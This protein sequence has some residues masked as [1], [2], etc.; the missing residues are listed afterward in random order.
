MNSPAR[1]APHKP[2]TFDYLGLSPRIRKPKRRA[3]DDDASADAHFTPFGTRNMR[4]I[5]EPEL[6]DLDETLVYA[7]QV[8][9][10][11]LARRGGADRGRRRTGRR[12]GCARRTT[13]GCAGRSL[14]RRRA[15]RAR[16]WCVARRSLWRVLLTAAQT[17]GRF[18]PVAY[19]GAGRRYFAPLNG[20]IKPDTTRVRQLLR[21]GGYL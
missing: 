3:P 7:F 10:P 11:P 14:A 21:E 2:P 1:T 18:F 15:L 6:A 20:N 16:A 4:P 9:V 8:S 5:E 17:D 13:S 19:G 12:C